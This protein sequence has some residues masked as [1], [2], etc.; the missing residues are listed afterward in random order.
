MLILQKYGLCRASDSFAASDY[1]IM[2][3][4]SIILMPLTENQTWHYGCQPP[5]HCNAIVGQGAEYALK[6]LCAD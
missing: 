5:Q 6:S 3:L 1:T 2:L 4:S